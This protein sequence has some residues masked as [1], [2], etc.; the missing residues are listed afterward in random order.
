MSRSFNRRVC[1]V[2]VVL[3]A[4]V[5]GGGC[6]SDS[7]RASG[8]GVSDAVSPQPGSTID[9]VVGK[10]FVVSLDSNPTTGFEWSVQQAPPAIDF[11]K[12]SFQ[13]PKRAVIGAPGMQRLTFK[14]TQRGTWKIDLVYAQAGSRTAPA[15]SLSFS[16]RV[17]KSS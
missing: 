7:G 1:V 5:V 15:K 3:V 13:T 14:A 2:A 17:A 6:G 8:S 9:A 10:P 12:S 4:L 11:V 16:V